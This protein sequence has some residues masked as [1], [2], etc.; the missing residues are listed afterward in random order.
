MIEKILF[1]CFS[2]AIVFFCRLNSYSSIFKFLPHIQFKVNKSKLYYG[3]KSLFI[4]PL[5]LLMFS[6]LFHVAYSTSDIF[7]LFFLLLLL[8]GL[9][10]QAFSCLSC[11]L[12][13]LR[14]FFIKKRFSIFWH[15][16][17]FNL[18]LSI[19]KFQVEVKL[20]YL[21]LFYFEIT[22]SYFTI[23]FSFH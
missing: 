21:P 7:E 19:I 15:F 18:K 22:K 4:L 13:N 12:R 6:S 16:L 1:I 10:L 3:Q 5:A 9:T 23:T 17:I 2:V 14:N 11:F 20:H 8:L